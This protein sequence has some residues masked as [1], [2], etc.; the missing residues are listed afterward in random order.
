M[1]SRAQFRHRQSFASLT[2]ARIAQRKRRKRLGKALA[3]PRDK[4][5]LRALA[6]K[7][8]AK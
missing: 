7:L 2:E 1:P 4:A 6:A 8:L 5:S 3:L